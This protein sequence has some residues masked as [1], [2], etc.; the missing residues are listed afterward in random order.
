[1]DTQTT[2][3]SDHHRKSTSWYHTSPETL[4]DPEIEQLLKQAFTY[5]L[6]DYT[7]IRFTLATGLRNSEVLG[8]NVDHVKPYGVITGMLKLPASIAK[9]GKPRDIPL[10]VA[11]RELLKRYI[12]VDAP[13]L[14]LPG[15]ENPLFRAKYR[16][17]RLG[18]RDFQDITRKHALNSIGRPCNPHMLRHTFA[19]KL[20]QQSNL[21]IVQ[22][23][24]GHASIQNTQIYTHPSS[25]DM[26]EA[27]GKM[28]L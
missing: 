24:L 3:V 14:D 11:I 5:S 9:G 7:L 8:L 21:R 17:N 15:Y 13:I 19:T 26:V 22:Q 23:I 1:M 6:R 20:L 12:D 16:N 28:N 18:S 2:S 4:T 10:H 27:I 25:G